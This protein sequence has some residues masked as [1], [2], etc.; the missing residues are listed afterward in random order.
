MHKIRL[1]PLSVEEIKELWN[2]RPLYIEW[3]DGT[4]SLLQ[5][6]GYSLQ[7]A[8]DWCRQGYRIYADEL[9]LSKKT[10]NTYTA[11]DI[12]RLAQ[13]LIHDNAENAD[14][15]DIDKNPYACGVHDGIIDMLVGLGLQ[16]DDEWIN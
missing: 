2:I 15:N 6:N 8:I 7:H 12:L 3:K 9:C 5:E 11:E 1:Q 16:I 10:A 13:K 4:D 14:A